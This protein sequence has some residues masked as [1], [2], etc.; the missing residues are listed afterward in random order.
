MQIK[1]GSR[2]GGG[3]KEGK[4]AVEMKLEVDR[5]IWLASPGADTGYEFLP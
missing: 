3:W 1:R 4:F 2:V 5:L